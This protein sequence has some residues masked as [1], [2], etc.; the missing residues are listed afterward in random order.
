MTQTRFTSE[1]G[2]FR[3]IASGDLPS[4]PAAVLPDPLTQPQ[5]ITFSSGRFQI[6]SSTQVQF[7]PYFG[8]VVKING[9]AFAIPA[10]GVLATYGNTFVGGVAGQSLVTNTRYLVYVFNNAGT[11][12]L[13]FY[14]GGSH[15]TSSTA[16]NVGTEIRSGDDSRTLVG[17]VN[18]VG[19]AP[20]QFFDNNSFHGV[21]SWFNRVEK[22][23]Y[24][25]F[26][27]N[28]STSTNAVL[29]QLGTGSLPALN[30]GDDTVRLGCLTQVNDSTNGATGR[31][32]V[33]V[34]TVGNQFASAA[35]FIF[36]IGNA[37]L[38][39]PVTLYG[40]VAGLA[41][42]LHN[43]LLSAYGS[44]NATASTLSEINANM[45]LTTHG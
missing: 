5:A 31:I 11:L 42:G 28:S 3:P 35:Q 10:A 32:Q 45:D 7:A 20:G 16:G 39:Y 17:M 19:G 4:V 29:T 36:S 13:D 25:S 14:T 33:D 18:T 37:N 9:K 6:V 38:F 34:D 27:N 43:Y 22:V 40:H 44:L 41:E 23:T 15:T 2:D 12:A 24:L 30:W 26:G 8:D 21:L 1:A